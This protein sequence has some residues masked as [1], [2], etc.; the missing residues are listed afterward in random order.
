MPIEEHPNIVAVK[1]ASGNLDQI[2]EIVIG[3][4]EGFAV[5]SGDDS[6]TWPVIS[7]GGPAAGTRVHSP[8]TSAALMAGAQ[9][10][11]CLTTKPARVW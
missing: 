11:T 3:A 8:L 1:E 2:S 6:L 5:L 4:P 10:L 9:S 7:V